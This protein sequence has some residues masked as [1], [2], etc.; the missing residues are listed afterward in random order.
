M[1]SKRKKK[2]K[3]NNRSEV[4]WYDTQTRKRDKAL[5]T[6]GISRTTFWEE[7]VNPFLSSL[8]SY[9]YHCKMTC[10]PG[11]RKGRGEPVAMTF[12]FDVK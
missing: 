4:L 1:K 3:K 10:A 8:V 6:Q 7:F 11:E 5:H 9:F 12:F 2:D